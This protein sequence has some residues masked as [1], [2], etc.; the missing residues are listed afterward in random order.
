MLQIQQCNLIGVESTTDR[1]SE[2]PKLDES[3]SAVVDI[4]EGC[5]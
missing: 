3:A 1:K 2:S 5:G 4:K